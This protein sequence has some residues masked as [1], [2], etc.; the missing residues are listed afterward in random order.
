MSEFIEIKDRYKRKRQRLRIRLGCLQ[1]FHK[2]VW[3]LLWLPMAAAFIL[4]A[5]GQKIAA[6]CLLSGDTIPEVLHPLFSVLLPI[7]AV[8][9][10]I[11]LILA[12]LE[13]IGE[14]TARRNRRY[15]SDILFTD[16]I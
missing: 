5:W 7:T 11:L 10:S 9:F 4:T 1:L 12:M 13:W 2:P 15:R 3:N 16:T 14:R 6:G 8:M